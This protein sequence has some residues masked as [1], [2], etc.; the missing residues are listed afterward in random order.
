LNQS[1]GVGRLCRVPS[2]G[3]KNAHHSAFS[4]LAVGRTA[5]S[6][7]GVRRAASP[8]M[9]ADRFG[10][11]AHQTGLAGSPPHSQAVA[12]GYGHADTLR[13]QQNVASMADGDLLTRDGYPVRSR[14]GA[15][16][17]VVR[18]PG[19]T[20]GTQRPRSRPGASRTKIIPGGELGRWADGSGQVTRTIR[21][22]G[23]EGDC[24]GH[25]TREPGECRGPVRV[26]VFTNHGAGW[27][28]RICRTRR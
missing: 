28:L 7:V 27:A 11:S 25:L 2:P 17:V 23:G 13:D 10:I 24:S 22:V 5:R 26:T 6:E 12:P 21:R 19:H 16:G 20:A 15:S 14:P 1:P 4:L 18:G 3:E 8:W 9:T